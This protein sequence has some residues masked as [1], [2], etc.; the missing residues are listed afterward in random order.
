M[1]SISCMYHNGAKRL[2]ISELPTPWW[3]LIG[4]SHLSIAVSWHHWP[5][6]DTCIYDKNVI[7]IFLLQYREAK[8]IKGSNSPG[9]NV[10]DTVTLNLY[11][12]WKACLHF[13]QLI[14]SFFSVLYPTHARQK[15]CES[16]TMIIILQVAQNG[17]F[18]VVTDRQIALLQKCYEQS[19]KVQVTSASVGG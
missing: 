8:V 15:C 11:T 16:L 10:S 4:A 9:S 3:G 2:Y 18:L 17:P 7:K 12:L 14:I 5:L 1:K 6:G 19:L 13:F